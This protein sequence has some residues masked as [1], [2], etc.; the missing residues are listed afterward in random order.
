MVTVDINH[1]LI[2][3]SEADAKI[4]LEDITRKLTNYALRE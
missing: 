2:M 4:D 3:D 1:V